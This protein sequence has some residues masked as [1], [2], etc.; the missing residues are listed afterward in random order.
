MSLISKFQFG[1]LRLLIWVMPILWLHALRIATWEN[2][3]LV[4]L[5]NRWQLLNFLEMKLVK[6]GTRSKRYIFQKWCHRCLIQTMFMSLLKK[7]ILFCL[8]VEW[9]IGFSRKCQ[10]PKDQCVMQLQGWCQVLMG[11]WVRRLSSLADAIDLSEFMIQTRDTSIWLRSAT[12]TSS[13]DSTA[14]W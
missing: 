5:A 11:K 13:R 1:T 4:V 8:I 12:S 3:I 7:A 6:T 9:I 14:F 2:M 10:V